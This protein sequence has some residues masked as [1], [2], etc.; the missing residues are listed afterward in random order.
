[1]DFE[2]ASLTRL[3][4]LLVIVNSGCVLPAG[5]RAAARTAL[6][7]PL[8]QRE[9]VSWIT[10]AIEDEIAAARDYD[11]KRIADGRSYESLF[12][13]V[14]GGQ[15]VLIEPFRQVTTRTVIRVIYRLTDFGWVIREAA[16]YPADRLALFWLSYSRNGPG[17]DTG[18]NCTHALSNCKLQDVDLDYIRMAFAS[19]WLAH[20]QPLGPARDNLANELQ[21][22]RERNLQRL[23]LMLRSLESD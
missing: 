3:V 18:F 17:T 13:A 14:E 16:V 6:S 21:R 1:M 15:E 20:Y 7:V 12:F 2:V 9:I 22:A 8:P 10:Q 19:W 5:P 23:R 4:V 11:E